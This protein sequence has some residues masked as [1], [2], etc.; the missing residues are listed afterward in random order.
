[1][2]NY[3]QRRLFTTLMTI[4]ATTFVIAI[5]Q[6]VFGGEADLIADVLKIAALVAVSTACLSFLAWTITHKTG[7][8]MIRGALAG[9]ITSVLIIPL[10]IFVWSLKTEIVSAYNNSTE[11]LFV[12]VGSAILPAINR[13]LYTFIDITKASLIAVIASMILGA[14]ISRYGKS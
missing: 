13:G 2:K 3:S 9:F 1:M 7:G 10:P 12:A 14:F 11:S 4:F 6:G 8:G 5:A